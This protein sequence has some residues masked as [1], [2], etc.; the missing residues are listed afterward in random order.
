MIGARIAGFDSSAC[1]LLLFA[2]I[3]RPGSGSECAHVG[4]IGGRSSFGA[5]EDA[6]APPILASGGISASE[7]FAAGLAAGVS[8][9]L[10]AGLP[11]EGVC[12]VGASAGLAAGLAIGNADGLLEGAAD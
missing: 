1:V 7:G 4:T 2:Q 6:P 9:G 5:S 8:A 10:P 3:G 11:A 12:A